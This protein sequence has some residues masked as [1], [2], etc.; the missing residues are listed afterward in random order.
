MNGFTEQTRER[1]VNM[2][3]VMQEVNRREELERN[4]QGLKQE[5]WKVVGVVVGVAIYS[6]GVNLFLR[7]LHL[8]S[9]GFMGFA[10]LISTVLREKMGLPIMD[11]SGIIYYLMNVPGLVIAFLTVRKRFA[12]KTVITVTLMTVLLTLIPIPAAPI[13]EEKIANCLIAGIMPEWGSSF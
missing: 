8:Y 5:L 13:L 9:G 11:I 1:Q 12:V 3:S 2:D 4:S 7:P 6:V 10:Q